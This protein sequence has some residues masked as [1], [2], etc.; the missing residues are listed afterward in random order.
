MCI[1]AISGGLPSSSN[2]CVCLLHFCLASSDP[3]AL[4]C[5]HGLKTNDCETALGPWK[6]LMTRSESLDERSNMISG[7]G[8]SICLALCR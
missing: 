7:L 6:E 4:H 2:M 5:R 3:V 8:G 1:G